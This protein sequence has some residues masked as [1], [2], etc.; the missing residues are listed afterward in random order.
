MHSI[1]R[2]VQKA[3]GAIR[4]MPSAAVTWKAGDQAEQAT[5]S[6]EINSL[7]QVN[8]L[9]RP[10]ARLDEATLR[11]N[12]IV[13]FDAHAIPSRHY[14]LLRDQIVN[15]HQLHDHLVVA[16][17]GASN[18]SGT[19]V[20]AANLAFTFARDNALHVTLISTD[21]AFG[22]SIRRHFGLIAENERAVGAAFSDEIALTV[23]A[24]DIQVHLISLVARD[25]EG[26]LAGIT[27]VR[28]SQKE[29]QTV[30]IIDLPPLP[31]S[32]YATSY[33]T[34][35]TDVVVVMA[36]D[37]TTPGDV[38]SCKS[39]LGARKGVHYVLNKSGRHG[40]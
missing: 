27:R 40:L 11:R 3:R 2:A 25:R 35:A 23:R 28:R 13:S 32:S 22:G 37:E 38:Q 33:I 15:S 12:M 24:A 18:A 7:H 10:T 36:A 6:F 4:S 1:A 19:T 9:P 17:T 31:T 20:T 16:V 21:D 14:D 34:H 5:T 39:V 8:P 26:I 29:H 30:T